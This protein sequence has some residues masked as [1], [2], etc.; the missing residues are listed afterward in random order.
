M[1]T[2]HEHALSGAAR[3]IETWGVGTHADGR[4]RVSRLNVGRAASNGWRLE[5]LQGA[6]QSLACGS[7]HDSGFGCRV[8]FSSCYGGLSILRVNFAGE[9]APSRRPQ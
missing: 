7:K 2:G 5:K 9:R 3:L 4:R 1:A 6:G 8:C